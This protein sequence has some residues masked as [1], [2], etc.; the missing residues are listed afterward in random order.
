MP[1]TQNSLPSNTLSVTSEFSVPSAPDVNATSVD[2]GQQ[3]LISI[4]VVGGVPPYSY[5]FTVSNATSGATVAYSGNQVSYSDSNSFA[6]TAVSAGTF[7][8][9]AIVTESDYDSTALNSTFSSA[10]TV[11]TA[12]AGGGLSGPAGPA[13]AP[14]GNTSSNGHNASAPY[15]LNLVLNG[16]LVLVKN[17]TIGALTTLD[18]PG[19]PVAL[20]FSPSQSTNVLVTNESLNGTVPRL[21]GNYAE[22]EA[23]G[24]GLARL[25]TGGAINASIVVTLNYSC[26]IAAA[27]LQPFILDN[28]SWARIDRFSV[29]PTACSVS[30]SIPSEPIVALGALP[31]GTPATSTTTARPTTTITALQPAVTNNVQLIAA[32]LIALA[33]LLLLL[34]FLWRGGLVKRWLRGLPSRRSVAGAKDTVAQ[35]NANN[36][37]VLL[38]TDMAA[39]QNREAA[40]TARLARRHRVRIVAFAHGT[41]DGRALASHG[42]VGAILIRQVR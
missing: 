24:I 8:A 12:G 35:L 25:G 5:N 18:V 7:R 17:I 14:S 34:L 40:D 30:F 19:L 28:G 27:R 23:I 16:Q 41:R 33:L 22:L 37:R 20:A 13:T 6:Y 11:S 31:V 15:E 29:N 26:G 1:E 10:F 32:L 39:R 38:V 21:P 2:V 3:V 36:V 4:A 42:G 9:N